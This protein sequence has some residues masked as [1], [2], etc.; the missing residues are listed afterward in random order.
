MRPHKLTIS[1]FLAYG[2]VA[3]ID[4][5]KLYES[6]LFLVYG[7]TGAGKTSI[8]DAMAYALYGKVPGSRSADKNETYRSLHAAPDTP[9]YVECCQ[10][11]SKDPS[12][13]LEKQ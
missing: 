7:E 4:F 3:E 12:H 6:G 5:D 8:F 9:T 2:G 1:G 11:V 10:G 13:G